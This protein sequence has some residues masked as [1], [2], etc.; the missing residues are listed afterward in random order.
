MGEILSWLLAR[1][2]I[3]FFGETLFSVGSRSLRVVRSLGEGGMG[4]VYE[5]ADVV[6]SD[7]FALKETR[8][9]GADLQREVNAHCAV[10]SEYVVPLVDVALLG[11]GV[12][13]G[14]GGI[15]ASEVA[16]E[17]ALLLFP[18][19]SGGTLGGAI[20]RRLASK[21]AGPVFLGAALSERDALVA[22]LSAARGLLA[23]HAA[24]L[25]HRDVKPANILIV[26]DSTGTIASA[27]LTDLGSVAPLY[28]Q[29]R[30]R[31]DAR[32]IE[33]DAAVR[34]SMPFRAPE[35]WSCE[36]SDTPLDG[37]AVDAWSLGCLLFASAFGVSPFEC[38]GVGAGGPLVLCEPSHT[39][40]LGAVAFPPP[41]ACVSADF[42]ALV[43][44]LLQVDVRLRL[45]V[46][47]AVERMQALLAG[48][49]P[50]NVRGP[51]I[52]IGDDDDGIN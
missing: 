26:F 48:L 40:T 1:L 14:R 7:K 3:L 34:T 52:V 20:A 35:L 22:S 49:T 36:P 19:Y 13:A 33:E 27:A 37:A 21:N 12:A 5:V 42:C 11:A 23:L 24:S 44:D 46:A 30:S 45:T 25:S 2:R 38:I 39:R 6:N 43:R 28:E 17:H 16:E 15:A 41:P 32:R 50:A 9:P 51:V 47:A 29:R 31:L 10:R 4:C 18:L 8:A